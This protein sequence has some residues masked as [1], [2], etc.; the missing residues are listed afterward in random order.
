MPT[1]GHDEFAALGSEFNTMSDQLAAYIDE[2][3][4]KRRELEDTIRRIGEAFAS[5]LDRQGVVELMVRTAVDACEADA[6]RAVPVDR[7]ALDAI[8][9]GSDEP[10]LIE[11]L[12]AAERKAFEVRPD[13]AKELLEPVAAQDDARAV[14]RQRRRRA[15]AR[16]PDARP[17]WRPQPRAA[18]GG[19][20]DRPARRGLHP[21]R[22]RS[23]SST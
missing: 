6:G 20:L 16:D 10:D 3:E 21:D 15:R 11:A 18:R 8:H 19:R 7:H 4:R 22:E 14:R 17:P 1:H 23:C 12:E 9:T 13:A 5:G 2:L